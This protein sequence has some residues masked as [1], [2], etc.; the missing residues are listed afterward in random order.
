MSNWWCY[1]CKYAF[2][3]IYATPCGKRVDGGKYVHKICA[4]RMIEERE[5]GENHDD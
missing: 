1:W 5:D 3:P 2:V 4:R